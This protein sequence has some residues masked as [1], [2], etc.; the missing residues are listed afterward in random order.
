MKPFTRREVLV[1]G[2]RI[3]MGIAMVPSACLLL[4]NCSGSSNES[5]DMELFDE[6][7]PEASLASLKITV[8]Y[9]NW[10][11]AP[12][13]F[14]DWGFACVLQGLQQTLLFDSG[15]IAST[16]MSNL[17]KLGIDH[18]RIDTALIS[19]EHHDHIGGL[20]KL[21]QTH[22]GMKVH[23]H[24]S[25]SSGYKKLL[26]SRK[27]QVVEMG[28]PGIICTHAA[29]TGEMHSRIKNE[30]ALVVRTDKGA[31]VIT[32]CAHPGILNI[33]HRARSLA[34][35]DILLVMGGFHL[36][37]DSAKSIRRIVDGF[38]QAGVRYVAPSH[39]S[40]EEALQLF[41]EAYGKRYIR[42]GAGRV[43][44][45]EILDRHSRAA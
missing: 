41:A 23:L 36:L 6:T 8:V 20:P 17:N 40:G 16:F 39:C 3:S 7:D 27:A 1:Y 10:S 5:M 42:S 24:A 43:I 35:Q 34:G 9:D 2:G 38:Q 13:M 22:P 33:V 26:R 45:A 21:L 12:G 4:S 15:R 18:Q 25:F 32:G 37:H 29:S 14:T 30:H 28:S 11:Y 44:D 31:I 19:H